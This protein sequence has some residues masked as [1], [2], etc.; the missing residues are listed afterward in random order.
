MLSLSCVSVCVCLLCV[1]I[2]TPISPPHAQWSRLPLPPSTS[3]A[4][5]MPRWVGGQS[6]HMPCRSTLSC[7]TP[8]EHFPVVLVTC[9]AVHLC[10][11]VRCWH[12]TH[13]LTHRLACTSYHIT[14]HHVT[15]LLLHVRAG[16]AAG[17]HGGVVP[18]RASAALRLFG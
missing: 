15:S 16:S 8:T 6:C 18:P 14:S 3:P 1:V 4:S 17:R 9:A 12:V 5:S 11:H 7:A 2:C 13:S 10:C